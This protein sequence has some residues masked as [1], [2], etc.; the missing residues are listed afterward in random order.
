MTNEEELSRILK[1]YAQ[2]IQEGK[3]NSFAPLLNLLKFENKPLTLKKHFQLEPIFRMKMPARMCFMT[4]R[5]VG[6]SLSLASQTLLNSCLIPYFHTLVIQPLFSQIRNFSNQLF[7]PLMMNSYILNEIYSTELENNMLLR[8]FKNGSRIHFS[9]SSDKDA[10]RT[11]GL[12]GLS[13]VCYDETQDIFEEII[14]IVTEVMSASENYGISQFTG[15]PLTTDNLLNQLFERGSMAEIVI[16]CDGCHKH[17]VASVAQDL[18]KMIGKTTCVCAKCGK[19]LDPRKGYFEHAIPE[20]MSTFL[21]YHICAVTHPLHCTKEKKWAEL[22]YKYETYSKTAFLNEVLGT[23]CDENVKL[24]TVG[25]LI[26]AANSSNNDKNEIK[27]RLGEYSTIVCGV[28]WGG[29]GQLQESTTAI[30]ILGKKATSKTLEVLYLE[31]LKFGI[32]PMEEVE[33]VIRTA[34]FFGAKVLAHDGTGAGA[35][36]ENMLMNMGAGAL[37]TIVPFTYVF[38]PRQ[39][40]IKYHPAQAGIRPYYTLDKSRSLYMTICAIKARQ[41]T[42]PKYE[43]AK[44]CLD[45]LFALAEEVKELPNSSELHRIVRGGSHP[46]D[47]AHAISF[48]CNVYWHISQSLP[49]LGSINSSWHTPSEEDLKLIAPD[50]PSYD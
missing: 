47:I 20:R 25:E 18:L 43:C 41:V 44:D 2:A 5:Q 23:P 8:S 17:N 32:S 19:P 4:S 49:D 11:R 9:Y 29:G 34:S 21:S 36:R 6:K 24:L 15:T 16:P 35:L 33:M 12:S 37:M 31:R 13:K 10:S 38:A 46:D 1:F 45:D 42:V 27:R 50:H 7:R 3:V 48:A 22:I 14:P 26:A 30:A 39:E 40:M 28:D